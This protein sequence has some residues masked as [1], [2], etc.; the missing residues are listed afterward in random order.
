MISKNLKGFS[1]LVLN[2]WIDSILMHVMMKKKIYRHCNCSFHWINQCSAVTKNQIL[3]TKC[4]FFVVLTICKRVRT[5]WP[6]LFLVWNDNKKSADI[7][8]VW[9]LVTSQTNEKN[10]YCLWVEDFT[11]PWP[12]I[13]WLKVCV[14]ILPSSQVQVCFFFLFDKY[15]KKSN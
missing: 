4:Q 10:K 15:G 7:W 5:A 9:F 2:V 14:A 1:K 3:S 8:S 6:L 12:H 11:L 13:L